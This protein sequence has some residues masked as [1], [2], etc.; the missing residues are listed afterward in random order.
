MKTL[1]ERTFQTALRWHCELRY[2]GDSRG[3]AA[4]SFLL[5]LDDVAKCHIICME[6]STLSIVETFTAETQFQY[7]RGLLDDVVVFA[8][9]EYRFSKKHGR[10]AKRAIAL[11]RLASAHER[12]IHVPR[13]L[14]VQP[15]NPAEE[16]FVKGWLRPH[17]QLELW[18][19]TQ[20][21]VAIP[22]NV[23]RSAKGRYRLI[24]TNERIALVAISSLGDVKVCPL[25]P[26]DVEESPSFGWRI[27]NRQ[28]TFSKKNA[29]I[30]QDLAFYPSLDEPGRARAI[31]RT[32][33][34]QAWNQK[35]YRPYLQDLVHSRHAQNDPWMCL[36]VFFV[37]STLG[38]KA[39]VSSADVDLALSLIRDASEDAEALAAWW[40]AFG[41][42][43]EVG[44]MILDRLPDTT[45][46]KKWSL[47]FSRIL[48][49]TR[50]K[51]NVDGQ[52][53]NQID[54]H[55]ARHL[56]AA[57]EALEAKQ[58][59]LQIWERLPPPSLSDLLPRPANDLQPLD[60]LRG[61]RLSCLEGLVDAASRLQ[62]PEE[63]T[64]R[65]KLVQLQPLHL[66]YLAACGERAH[67]SLRERCD[68]VQSVLLEKGLAART[69]QD[70]DSW[71]AARLSPLDPQA[72][73]DLRHP[74]SLEKSVLSA[75]QNALHTT[76]A[77]DRQSLR[78]FCSR[79]V[80]HDQPVLMED[81]QDCVQFLGIPAV[82][83]FLSQGERDVGL[84]AYSIEQ[85]LL[86]IGGQHL[87]PDGLHTLSRCER[88]FA[89]ASELAH[90]AFGH[91]RA[92]PEQVW[93]GLWGKG[94]TGLDL[95][96][97]VAPAFKGW[98]VFER[99]AKWWSVTKEAAKKVTDAKKKESR[100][101]ELSIHPEELIAAHQ[102]MQLSADRAALVFSGDIHSALRAIFLMYRDKRVHL[103]A[104]E[105]RESLA[106]W[107]EHPQYA[108]TIQFRIR[109]ASL[110]S[111]YL[112]L[113]Y[114]RMFSRES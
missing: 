25:S 90:L 6:E 82:E 108:P 110:I 41:F 78:A 94:Q 30:L 106:S 62:D 98:A 112:S 47:I 101:Q 49:E 48:H 104:L 51:H 5:V 14:L 38:L 3:F 63:E 113:E 85:P 20:T 4:R 57:E 53:S 58:L 52:F 100:P 102:L 43:V 65:L 93:S 50:H 18:L 111:F 8:H 97:T 28:I 23:T 40:R 77:P 36:S 67:P 32:H 39:S 105:D 12:S 55:F 83:V 46:T 7:Q 44:L 86:L 92:T 99:V 26:D 87:E 10:A 66:N 24:C 45:E 80:P 16:Q 54:L 17:E 109:L 68:D 37:Q 69:D 27:A 22:S 19:R 56:N 70:E 72:I 11:S 81:V 114:E 79:V 35:K 13:S 9:G 74:S 2:E 71:E 21:S 75:M 107:M 1:W 59:L 29:S 88:R 76:S 61:Q 34:R 96:F 33:Y 89:I 31:L 42:E 103:S 64:Y 73:E 15:L 91:E 60:T 84:R 95:L